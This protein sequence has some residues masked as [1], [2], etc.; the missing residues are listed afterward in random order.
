MMFVGVK[1]DMKDVPVQVLLR[2][3]FLG[4]SGSSRL[5][6]QGLSGK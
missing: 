2:T 6:N 5:M 3:V 4:P 1:Y